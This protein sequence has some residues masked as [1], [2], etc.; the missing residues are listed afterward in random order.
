[1]ITTW[2]ETGDPT[3]YLLYN[4]D[5]TN[6]NIYLKKLNESQTETKFTITHLMTIAIGYGI[7]KV[8]RDIGRIRFGNFIKSEQIGVTVLVD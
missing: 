3:T 2:G 6:A 1:M 7:S 5:L 8:R 4:Y